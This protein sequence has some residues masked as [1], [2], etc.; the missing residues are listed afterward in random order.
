MSQKGCHQTHRGNLLHQISTDFNFF[1]PL[2]REG[3]LQ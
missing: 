2:E 3:N 1:S